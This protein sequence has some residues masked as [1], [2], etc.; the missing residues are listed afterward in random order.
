[1]VPNKVEA[2]VA[3]VVN[4][5]VYIVSIL[6]ANVNCTCVRKLKCEEIHLQTWTLLNFNVLIFHTISLFYLRTQVF[7]AYAR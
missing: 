5:Y 3:Q 7:R 1:M 2:K 6:F 4:F